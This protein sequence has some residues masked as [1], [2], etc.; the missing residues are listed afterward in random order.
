[1]A[2]KYQ[3]NQNNNDSKFNKNQDIYRKDSKLNDKNSYIIYELNNTFDDKDKDVLKES[4]NNKTNINNGF[5]S[6]TINNKLE[7]KR[8]YNRKK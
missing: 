3:E 1:M 6:K 8:K 7:N 5:V 2:N 4:E